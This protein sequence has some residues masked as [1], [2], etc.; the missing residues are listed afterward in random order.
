MN[1]YVKLLLFKYSKRTLKQK[2]KKK[3]KIT[4]ELLNVVKMQISN[5]TTKKKK[6]LKYSRLN[7]SARIALSKITRPFPMRQKKKN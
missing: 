5:N 3:S 2:N 6:Q 7:L 1:Y 4:I